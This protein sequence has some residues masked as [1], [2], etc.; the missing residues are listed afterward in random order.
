MDPEKDRERFQHLIETARLVQGKL[1]F[2][3]TVAVGGTAAA[4]YAE[5][6]VSLDVDFVTPYLQDHFDE[7]E[8]ALREIPEFTAARLR[9]PVLILGSVGEDEVGIRQLRRRE[10]LEA[11][12]HEGLWIPT[13]PE[14]IRVKSFVLSDRRAVRDF[15]DLCALV[16]LAGIDAAVEAM[17]PYSGLYGGLTSAGAIPAMAEAIHDEP[18]DLPYV[19]LK[20]WRLL[21]PEFQDLDRVRSVCKAFALRVVESE[22]E[23]RAKSTSGESQDGSH[24]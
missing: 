16:E 21:K 20:D 18:A 17:R 6:R 1:L 7:V 3:P 14:M 22:A 9:R 24:P 13:L 23:R 15:I 8:A 2:L 4:L 5:H 10:P 12:E 19:D 11:V